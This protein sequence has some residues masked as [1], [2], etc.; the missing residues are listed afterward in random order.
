MS[1]PRPAGRLELRWQ[2]VAPA[3][4]LLAL[5][6]AWFAWWAWSS[7]DAEPPAAAEPVEALPP[8]PEEP[9]GPPEP[10]AGPI[11]FPT[12][13]VT[14]YWPLADGGGL[15]PVEAEVF[16]TQRLSDRLKQVVELL[17]RGPSA[18]APPAP[19]EEPGTPA[20]EPETRDRPELAAPLP[21]GTLTR[22]VFLDDAGTAYVSLS[23][24]LISGAPGGSAWELAAV[25]S[26]VNSLVR[27]FPEVERVQLLVEG[28]DV[29]SIGGHLDARR[30]FSFNE[31]VLAPEEAGGGP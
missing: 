8:P 6:G 14:L 19:G 23:E 5:A 25:Y 21:P 10:E 15:R 17:A 31:R 9:S 11:D 1:E 3:V 24:Q 2:H 26:V 28:R 18:P 4:V 29:E 27:S 7:R 12:V 22:A 20:E 13:P 30:P 16:A